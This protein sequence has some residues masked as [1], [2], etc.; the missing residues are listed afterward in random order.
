MNTG[1]RTARFGLMLSAASIVAISAHAA[2]PPA[3]SRI[4]NQA[5]ATYTNASG[6][7][8]SVT[9]NKVETIVQQV[10][11]L[12]LLSDTSESATPGGRVFL[13]QTVTN[14]GNST[15]SFTLTATENAGGPFD[16]TNITIFAD[17]NFDGIAD[18]TTPITSTPV[19]AAGETFGFVIEA[20]VPGSATSG[21]A[22]TINVNATSVFD[23]TVQTTPTGTPGMQTTESTVTISTGPI[24]E[25]T[26]SMTVADGPGAAADGI[27]GA[28][29]IVTVTITYSSTG[30]TAANMLTVTD[31]LSQYLEYDTSVPAM[32]SDSATGLDDAATGFEQANGN[33]YQIDYSYDATAS[34]TVSGTVEFIIDQVPTGRT[35]SVTFQAIIADGAPAEDITNIATQT[36]EITPG[37]PTAFPPSN[38]AVINVDPVYRVTVADAPASSYAGDPD[39]ANL[40][41]TGASSTDDDGAQNDSVTETSDAFQGR[42]IPFEFVIT[43]HANATD[44]IDLSVTNDGVNGFPT[45]TT[46]QLV[47]ADGATPIV[48]PVGPLASNTST[49]VSVIATLP[50]NVAPAVA[51]STNYQFALTAQSTNG[52]PV[53]MSTGL[54]TGA[55]LGATVD[56]RNQ[57]GSG[58]GPDAPSNPVQT[59][60]TTNPGTPTTFEMVI[61]NQGPTADTF[62]LSLPSPLPPGWTVSF[63]LPDGTPITNTGIIP[64]GGTQP[65]TVIVT[66]PVNA[67]PGD[68]PVQV[69]VQ[70]PSTGQGDTLTN[71][72]TVNEIIDAELAADQTVQVAPG[73]IVD[74]AHSLTNKGNVT[75]TE[76]GI[77]PAGDFSAFSSTLFWDVNGDGIL[78]AGDQVIDNI[79][80][81]ASVTGGILAGESVSLIQRVQ[82]PL[83]GT[84]GLTETETLTLESSLNAPDETSSGTKT[85]M[86]PSNNSVTN[87]VVIV[88]GDLTLIKRQV[89]DADCDGG[90]PA[91][92][93]TLAEVDVRPGQCIRYEITASNTGTADA[94]SVTIQDILPGF[95]TL[96]ECAS[97]CTVT[98]TPAGSTIVSQP[99]E[100]G[101]GAMQS[102]HGTLIPGAPAT[103]AFTV[104][105]DE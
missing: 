22:E 28:G 43:N 66:P 61:E 6:D 97:A 83:S 10:A 30:L 65:V 35:G 9:S 59:T 88:S 71:Q 26:K 52:G 82:G 27:T 21:Q 67:L 13:P 91:S 90:E 98:V 45:G 63:E 62:N 81:I 92:A 18:S 48:G 64:S 101:T 46:F 19:L 70:S 94:G 89:L 7:T 34:A 103:L 86:D 24:T 69:A 93:F 32:W 53:N 42:A 25:I 17:A 96:T 23:N 80:D 5:S 39:G 11:G 85:D 14:E 16:F 105:V 40:L 4:G 58:S 8:I 15:D 57:D 56:L 31:E 38:G 55:I 33:G 84:I 68:T 77:T 12:T 87:T 51:G 74:I 104:K 20:T 99:S 95:T 29:D 54:F 60:Q 36:V 49:K 73:G 76:G 47:G 102:Q 41:S 78:D 100:G 1:K 2:A 72:V 50:T 44:T 75:L 3:G 79:A 37:T